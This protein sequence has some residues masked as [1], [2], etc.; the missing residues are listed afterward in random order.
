MGSHCL[1]RKAVSSPNLM[2]EPLHT[3]KPKR[4]LCKTPWGPL[5]KSSERA[6]ET[7]DD[8]I[9]RL[10]SLLSIWNL[11]P[12]EGCLHPIPHLTLQAQACLGSLASA[13]ADIYCTCL[14]SLRSTSRIPAGGVSPVLKTTPHAGLVTLD[15]SP[16]GQWVGGGGTHMALILTSCTLRLCET[17]M[18]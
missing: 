2:V 17:S 18:I 11:H 6:A 1:L 9:M 8:Y 3:R 14:G 7:I 15:C 4:E 12:A 13:S 16:R 10:V 5:L